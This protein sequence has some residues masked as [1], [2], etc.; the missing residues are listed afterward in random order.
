MKTV[1]NLGGKERCQL[2]RLLK[3][4]N[5]ARPYQ[6]ALALLLLDEGSTVEE[7]AGQLHVSRQ[8]VYNWMSRFEA[9]LGLSSIERLLDRERSGRPPTVQGVIDPLLKEVI[10]LD[11]RNLGYN[12]TT[13][14]ALLLRQHLFD[15][16]GL[17]VGLRS[18]GSAL[19]R[20]RLHWKHPRHMLSRRDPFWQQ[21]KGGLKEASGCGHA[22]WF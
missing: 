10:A 14:T 17:S 1:L 19:R 6:R 3:L 5:Q 16:Y 15:D 11:P 8:T 7:V 12:S 4:G 21:S 2:E 18:I 13:W 22:Q 9:R 20:L